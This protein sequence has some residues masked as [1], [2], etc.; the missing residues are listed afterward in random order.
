MSI[1]TEQDSNDNTETVSIF[2]CQISGS[3]V[4]IRIDEIHSVLDRFDTRMKNILNFLTG[5]NAKKKEIL[6]CNID[7]NKKR[8]NPEF[9]YWYKHKK[10]ENP[11]S[12]N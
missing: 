1:F 2:L 6:N 9:F 8:K 11:E 12:R 5:T 7:E 10:R 4:K 3:N